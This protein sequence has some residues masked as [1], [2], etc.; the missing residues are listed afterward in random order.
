MTLNSTSRAINNATSLLIAGINFSTTAAN[1]TV[2]LSSGT[3]TVTAATATQLT[4]T[5]GGT[6]SLGSLTA[7][8][9]V[10]G[11]STGA[12][13]VAT[14]VA[15]PTVTLSAANLAI[16]ATQILIAGTNF[17]TTAANN[18]V[19]LSSGIA[20]VTAATTTQLTA[21][22]GGTLSLGSLTANVTVFGG[23]TGAV[24]VAS[25][26]AAPTVTVNAASLAANAPTL[27]IT[28]TGFSTTAANNTVV[29]SSGTATVTVATA[30]QLTATLGG[31]L[32]LGSLTAVVTSNGGSSGAAVQAAT[33]VAA[34]TVTVN[35]SNLAINA[36]QILIAGTNFST[37]AANNTVVLSSGTVTVTAATATQL[38]A[39]LGGTLSLGSLTAVVTSNGGSSGT[40]IQ[41]A[42]V[43]AAPT[44]T[45]SA[46]SLAINASTITIAGTNFSTTAADNTVQ[47][48]DG[49]VGNVTAST[50]TQLT[51]AISTKPTAVG[52]LTAIVSVFGGSSGAAVQV[53]TVSPVVT[54]SVA[55]LAANAASVVINGFGFST[56]AASDLI[57]FNDGAIGSVTTASANSLT[58]T[59]STKPVNAGSLTAVVMVSGVS[60]GT[61]VQVATVI[62]VVTSSVANLSTSAPTIT[63][64]GFG[65]AS[66]NASNSVAFNLSAAG[67]VTT[68]SPTQIVVTFTTQPGAGGLTAVVTSNALSSGA[69]VQVGTAIA[70]PLITKASLPNWT[71]TKAGY[72]QTIGTSG[73]SGAITFAVTVGSL[74]AGLTLN[75]ATGVISGMPTVVNTFNFTV[76]AT[77]SLNGA[78]SQAYTIIINP[79][80]SVITTTLP[81]WT[82]NTPYSQTVSATGGTGALTVAVTLGSFPTGLYLSPGGAISGTPTVANTFNFTITATD[83]V[84][85]TSSQ[86]YTVV[87]NSAVVVTPVSLPN[88]TVNQSGYAQ[89]ITS[90]NGTG[91][92]ALGISAGAIPAGMSF[93]AVTGVLNGTPTA[94]G[95]S[96]FTITSTDAAGATGSRAYTIMIN[97]AVSITTATLLDW[98]ANKSGYSQTVSTAGGT[99]A[100]TLVVTLG[101]LPPGL[102]LTSG[103]LLSGTP[104]AIGTSTFTITATDSTGATAS[105]A[106]TVVIHGAA[107]TVA[108]PTSAAVTGTSATLGG[109]VVSDGGSTISMRGVVL[110]PTAADGNL[111][112]GGAGVTN[113]PSTGTTGVFTVPATSL[114]PGTAYSFAVYATNGQGTTYS[115]VGSFTTQSSNAGLA[116]LALSPGTLSPA[117]STNIKNYTVTLP[118]ITTSITFTPT[119]TQ[120]KATVQIDGTNV[121]SGKPGDATPLTVGTNNILVMVT[122]E[123]GTTISVYTVV[124]T[125]LPAFIS[126][127][128]P[129]GTPL[130]NGASV[131]DFGGAG[132]GQTVARVFTVKNNSATVLKDF[133]FVFDGANPGDFS[134]TTAP[135]A[136]LAIGGSTTFTL[137][138]SPAAL[139][140]RSAMVHIDA[141]GE[142]KNPFNIALTG[143]G[144]E[145]PALT[146]PPA[147]QIVPL[148]QPVP[149][150]AVASG[151]TLSYQWLKNN[152]TIPGATSGSYNLAAATLANAGGYSVT[153]TNAA[154]FATSGVAN[155]GVLRV[156]PASVTLINGN[157]LTL[158]ASAAGPGLVYRWLKNNTAM[159]DG[160]NSANSLSVIAGAHTT[161]L[162]VTKTA[163]ADNGSY[164]CL[165]TMPDPQTSGAHLS[166]SSGVFTVNVTSKPVLDSFSAGPWIVGG[167]VGDFITAQNNPTSFTLTGQPAGV[168]IDAS[169]HLHG[170]PMVPITQPTIYHL[171]ITARNAAGVAL[172][173][174]VADVTV[175]PL[176]VAAVGTFNGLVERDADTAS[177]LSANATKTLSFGGSLS[178]STLATGGFSGKLT[179]G[180]LSY[181]FV[182]Q[183]VAAAIGANPTATVTIPRTLPLHNLT[184][185]F[186]ID[187]DTGE[188]IGTVTDGVI[189]T[190]VN[191]HAWRGTAPL[192]AL[193]GS[194]TSVLDFTPGQTPDPTGN[195]DYPQG[196]GFGTLT[197]YATGSVTWTGKLSDGSAMVANTTVGSAGQ[198]PLHFMLYTTPGSAHGWVQV[199][200][201]STSTPTNAGQPLLDGALDWVKDAQATTS[202]NHNYKAGFLLNR[203]QLTVAG[204]KYVKPTATVLGI[205]DQVS[206]TNARLAFSAGGLAGSPPIADAS[207]AVQL[208]STLFRITGANTVVMPTG[209][210]A[211]PATLT[212]A[213]TASSGAFSGSFVLKDLDPTNPTSTA[214]LSRTVH[215]YG[216]IVQ[217]VSVNKALGFFLL[218]K[219]P[220][221]GPPKTTLATSDIL[222]GSVE[223][224]AK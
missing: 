213:L 17:S 219:L 124:V 189:A 95:L 212:L 192:A 67:T 125:R 175:N 115:S 127:Q 224:E 198:I 140:G 208:N 187:K 143:T 77:D 120:A 12:V 57:V 83:T 13:Q 2:V 168:T 14:I 75:S 179:L 18:T 134:V 156:V 102:T 64:N 135:A 185:T 155:L 209:A 126:V 97:P 152:M 112:T 58:V 84:G 70:P 73:G 24:Q 131:T 118:D 69:A 90:A 148:G 4:V 116:N 61:A 182:N 32:S 172:I 130:V 150:N 200:L 154:G 35:A 158:T 108:A 80:V 117:F 164:T 151:G 205:V 160:T 146:I 26:V 181:S 60:S 165:V 10:F 39:T 82:A 145:Q 62:P 173:P 136:T 81:N 186:A 157:T 85:A 48:N 28:G 25:V 142:T 53:A 178:L 92:R 210:S 72:L 42:T 204:G 65:F 121:A 56:T 197:V 199:S 55:N 16:N 107:P 110:A 159:D 5:L 89:T 201:D 223:L 52:N 98:T 91:A 176:P 96:S 40:A 216:L 37:T 132:L 43:V 63:V 206:P 220:E 22:L 44:V 170:K 138:F 76:T 137:T 122:A 51:V 105:Q 133:V 171:V 161:K 101:S 23:S 123:D 66:S 106:Y 147:S 119:V 88:W 9:T 190:P 46:A 203:L 109:N 93:T 180:T 217:R 8:V 30:T 33:I 94:S 162:T 20:T 38:T 45:L 104:S 174:A 218:S 149:F 36:T 59:F 71:V 169:G 214:M 6:L 113:I 222:S 191:V 211:N 86:G 11:G 103:G 163:A 34:P 128:Q 31:T 207:M 183:F 3:A 87:I 194:Y 27:I 1:N 215:Y 29:L 79:A 7:N 54:A 19:V 196:Y 193:V 141:T 74:P 111:L 21:T 15:A 153:V 188:L 184:L 167:V 221:N 49:A 202:T 139:G 99:G 195:L 68:S 144:I 50:A 47:F 114:S 41:V 166:L 129:V 78:R 177:G 100:A